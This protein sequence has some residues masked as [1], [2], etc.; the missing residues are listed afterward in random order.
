MTEIRNSKL[1]WS[2]PLSTTQP[3][4]NCFDHWTLEFEVYL[5]FV[6]WCLEF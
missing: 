6:I 2:E 1:T 5:E 3:K 4:S